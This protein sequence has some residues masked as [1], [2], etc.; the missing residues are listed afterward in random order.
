M[1][2]EALADLVVLDLSGTV[3]TGYCGHL[4]AALGARVIDVE[5]PGTGHP[6]RRL[7]PFAPSSGGG[8]AARGA[9]AFHS[10]IAARKE[11]VELD[12]RTP[13]GRARL[14]ELCASAD[15]LL[16]AFRPGELAAIGID[17]AA[18]EA[19]NPALIVVSMPWFGAGGP[20]AGF[21][22]RRSAGGLAGGCRP[23]LRPGRGS[24]DAP[25]RPRLADRRRRQRVHR[26]TRSL[27]RPRARAHP[28]RA[29]RR[30]R[31]GGEPQPHRPRHHRRLQRLRGAAAPRLEPLLADLSGRDL[32]RQGRL[33]RRHLRAVD[34]VAEPV[35]DA[36][37]ARSDRRAALPDHHRAHGRRRAARSQDRA[38]P[39]AAHGR[40]VVSPGP[41]AAHSVRDGAHRGR[42]AGAASS[43]SIAAHSLATRWRGTARSARPACRFAWRRRR[44]GRVA[45]RLAWE[46]TQGSRSRARRPRPEPVAP[47]SGRCAAG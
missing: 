43:S 35:R 6:T 23:H 14:L 41:G 26:N 31:A 38:R 8:N 9:S 16:E 21:A 10:W 40:G 45:R 24:A 47:C 20:L 12:P 4:M 22:R 44:R 42:S 28:R 1:T 39:R 27:D 30:Q 7:P 37:A 2:R 3:A 13:E 34:A 36:R 46:N 29:R 5:A 32:S 17:R 25:E 33:D 18:L 19:A 15:V 11:S